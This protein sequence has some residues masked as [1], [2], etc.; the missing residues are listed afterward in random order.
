MWGLCLPP[1]PCCCASP[2][3]FKPD[4][5]FM[6][7]CV[8]VSHT[9]LFTIK[10]VQM[11]RLLG[12][13]GSGAAVLFF[14]S[15]FTGLGCCMSPP[16]LFVSECPSFLS[17]L[18]HSPEEELPR[19]C[20]RLQPRPFSSC[21]CPGFR[22][23]WLPAPQRSGALDAGRVVQGALQAR[24]PPRLRHASVVRPPLRRRGPASGTTLPRNGSIIGSTSGRVAA[25]T[26][27]S[28]AAARTPAV[29][30]C[31]LCHPRAACDAGGAQLPQRVRAAAG[32]P[33][34][35]P[36]HDG[37]P[38][39]LWLHAQLCAGVPLL[40]DQLHTTGTGRQDSG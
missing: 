33:G 13:R 5:A 30:R 36:A 40:L 14:T 22:H 25:V 35:Q 38:P 12:V 1:S 37:A 7:H 20:Q 4:A 26:V 28:G 16:L 2:L 34:A 3:R 21:L 31:R 23:L 9:K 17:Y 11:I 10:N 6:E 29:P 19:P 15:S 39:R 27:V 8:A 32:L 24:D 18:R